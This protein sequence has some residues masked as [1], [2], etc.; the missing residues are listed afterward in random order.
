MEGDELYKC[1]LSVTKLMYPWGEKRVNEI[2]EHG[3]CM[4]GKK[5]IKVHTF[6]ASIA[7]KVNLVN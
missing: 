4:E 5:S 3:K 1:I 6:I 2:N 7:R